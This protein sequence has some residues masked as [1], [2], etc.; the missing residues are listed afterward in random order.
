MP[1]TSQS[2]ECTRSKSS[3]SHSSA[4]SARMSVVHRVDPAHERVHVLRV[5]RLAHAVHDHAVALLLGR[6][7]PAA[8][9][10]HVHLHALAHQ[11]LGQ[12]A[13][14]PASPPST[15]G[16]YS[17]EIRR[18][19][20]VAAG[21]L[22]TYALQHR[23]TRHE[24]RRA[25]RASGPLGPQ[26]RARRPARTATATATS[27]PAHEGAHAGRGVERL[28]AA[29]ERLR[30]ARAQR[31]AA[32][33]S[34]TACASRASGARA[35]AQRAEQRAPARPSRPGG[36]CRDRR[37]R[38]RAARRPGRCRARPGRSASAATWPSAGRSPA[39]RHARRERL[40][41]VE[42][43]AVLVERAR[44]SASRRP[45][46]RSF[47]VHPVGVAL[48]LAQRLLHVGLEALA[49]RSARRRRASGRGGTPPRGRAA[50]PA[51][52][53]SLS[54]SQ[55]RTCSRP[56]LGHPGQRADPRAH[57]ARAL[58]VV[59]LGGEQAQREALGALGVGARGSV[60]TS[61]PKRAGS[62]P[63]SFSASSRP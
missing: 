35:G 43:R 36:G 21:S 6:Q 47:A 34:A 15:T 62:P 52:S 63:T 18:I 45:P 5:G 32:A 23:D 38:G 14:V 55:R 46:S 44:R 13:H 61:M 40:E 41:V 7:A 28:V 39:S 56:L 2:C 26:R 4:P 25:R 8:A 12:L 48:G 58:G 31:R 22:P 51:R 59:G 10:E 37:A 50:P 29:R 49:P 11:L 33:R 24:R 1:A 60:S 19:R 54:S 42:E 30:P 9:S 16:G 53:G 3:R 20:K 17:Q 27:P 57:V